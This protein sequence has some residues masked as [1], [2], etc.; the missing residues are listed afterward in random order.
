MLCGKEFQC[1]AAPNEK[2]LCPKVFV[3]VL[4]TTRMRE[5]E[6]ERRVLAGM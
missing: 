3:L 1:V 6:D 4:G 5:S 2:V